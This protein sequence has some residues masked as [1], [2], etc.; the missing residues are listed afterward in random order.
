MFLNFQLPD[1]EKNVLI[2]CFSYNNRKQTKNW[3]NHK[4]K[5]SKKVFKTQTENKWKPKFYISDGKPFR[6][7]VPKLP[8]IYLLQSVNNAIE[9]EYWGFSLEEKQLIE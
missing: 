6:N 2:G 9:P 7:Q 1:Y 3:N 5:E 8:P 4:V